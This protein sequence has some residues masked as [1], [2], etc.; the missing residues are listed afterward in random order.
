MIAGAP[1][2]VFFS[3]KCLLASAKI[4]LGCEA[5]CGLTSSCSDHSRNGLGLAVHCK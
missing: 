3:T 4:N 5:G 2:V 1:N